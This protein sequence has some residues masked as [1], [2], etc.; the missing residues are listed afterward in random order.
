MEVHGNQQLGGL[1]LSMVYGIVKSHSGF[2][3]LHSQPQSGTTFEILFPAAADEPAEGLPSEQAPPRQGTGSILIVE[4]DTT[5]RDITSRILSRLGYDVLVAKDGPETM[6]LLSQNRA[7]IHLLLV[8]LLTPSMDGASLARAVHQMEPQIRI[9]AFSGIGNGAGQ[10]AKLAALQSA[11]IS[12][13]L[14]KPY[15]VAELMRAIRD[16]L[17]EARPH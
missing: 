14:S 15:T 10:T 11:G 17:R 2:I 1:G 13:V 4:S 7:R 6:G 5:L 3:D 16:E 9:L 12:R 8:N